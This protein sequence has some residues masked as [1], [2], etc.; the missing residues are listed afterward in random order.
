MQCIRGG[1]AAHLGAIERL[2]HRI[3]CSVAP[4]G[5]DVDE[6]LRVDGGDRA[7]GELATEARPAVPQLSVGLELR[8]VVDRMVEP[9]HKDPQPA[10]TAAKHG[11]LAGEAV[12]RTDELPARPAASLL[13]LLPQRAVLGQYKDVEAV[14]ER[15]AVRGGTPVK[16]RVG[17]VEARLSRVGGDGE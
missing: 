11:G 3:Q 2:R 4:D 7:G 10:V 17:E 13:P 15:E 6:A 1:C 12:S 14:I 5:E 16:R 8:G 9:P